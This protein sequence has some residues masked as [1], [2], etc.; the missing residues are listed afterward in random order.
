MVDMNIEAYRA[1]CKELQTQTPQLRRRCHT[2]LQPDFSCYCA[3]IQPFDAGIEFVIL[4]HPI[5]V[6]RRRI[7][8]G[9]MTHL[10]LLNSHLI[11][12]QV[13]TG[14]SRVNRI[15]GDPDRHCVLL[16]PGRQSAN[17]SHM[18][19]EGRRHITPPGKRLC[20]FVIDGT[21]ATAKKT[22]NQ[23]LNLKEMRR[24]CF[25][26]SSPSNFRVRQQPRPDCYSTIEA[27]HQ[28]IDMLGPRTQ[29]REH[30]RLLRV[31]DKMI[32]RQLE[33]AH[34]DG[35]AQKIRV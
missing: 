15:L 33:L 18:S 28:T 3:W 34:A 8:T 31:F 10:S 11:M 17:L 2:C 19:A 27:V 25:T 32:A 30:D 1:K 12:G 14:D 26:P 4:I 22:V 6:K 23:S 13:Y 35:P 5:E 24:L 21:W 16:Y 7:T 9:R 20:V 29:A